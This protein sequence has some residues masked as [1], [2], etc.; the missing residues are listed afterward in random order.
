MMQQLK[1][2]KINHHRATGSFTSFQMFHTHASLPRGFFKFT[3][4]EGSYPFPE[5]E[6]ASKYRE[7][8]SNELILKLTGRHQ[9]MPPCVMPG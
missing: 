8:S 9:V 6:L 3:R 4:S 1:T 5:A 2:T 7:E